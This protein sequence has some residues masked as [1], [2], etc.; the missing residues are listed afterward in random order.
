MPGKSVQLYEMLMRIHLLLHDGDRQFFASRKL[1]TPRFLALS[2]ILANP[3]LSLS[4]LA[5]RMLCTKGN[6]SRILQG[7]EEMGYSSRQPHETDNR[8]IRLYLTNEGKTLV[9]EL[10]A[11]HQ[12]YTQER[13]AILDSAAQEQLLTTLAVL[14]NGFQKLLAA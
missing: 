2:H 4:D 8:V 10:S 11:A 14:A 12:A 1:T 6:A 5:Q 3:G 7:L 13:F 9:G